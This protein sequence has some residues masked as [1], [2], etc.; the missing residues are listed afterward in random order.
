MYDSSTGQARELNRCHQ[1][2]QGRRIMSARDKLQEA[3]QVDKVILVN[4]K[5]ML[6]LEELRK[7]AEATGAS[8]E[9]IQSLEDQKATVTEEIIKDQAIKTEALRIIN[10]LDKP[11]YRAMLTE[12]YIR[13]KPWELIADDFGYSKSH[14][15]KM[16]GWALKELE[17]KEVKN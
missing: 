5:L 1:Y 10:T 12:H 2:G 6:E 14:I 16:H 7:I 11:L 8:P 4:Q 15:E 13:G 9:A 3:R 17:G